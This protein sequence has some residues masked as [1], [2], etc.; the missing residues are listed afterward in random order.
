MGT[1][2]PDLEQWKFVQG[3]HKPLVLGTRVR[4]PHDHRL[5][6]DWPD[7]Y[8]VTGLVVDQKNRIDITIGPSLDSANQDGWDYSD[9]WRYEI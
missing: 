2:H 7:T 8:V 4:L 1:S 5:K 3:E 6:Q 9:D